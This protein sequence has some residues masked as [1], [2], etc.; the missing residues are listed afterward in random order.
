M[1]ESNRV[2]VSHITDVRHPNDACNHI[3]FQDHPSAI[4]AVNI[5]VYRGAKSWDEVTRLA[6]DRL[7]SIFESLPGFRE[8]PFV[9]SHWTN[10]HFV[11]SGRSAM[12][13]RY[14]KSRA[15]Q[16]SPAGLVHGP[17]LELAR[18]TS[19]IAYATAAL[20]KHEA[21]VETIEWTRTQYD[22]HIFWLQDLVELHQSHIR[23]FHEWT[24]CGFDLDDPGEFVP[25]AM[26]VAANGGLYLR[27]WGA[28]DDPE[29]SIQLYYQPDLVELSTNE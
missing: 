25:F 17:E 26:S 21:L 9:L 4:S 28:F 11:G 13:K 18:S 2:T 16:S 3:W 10:I 6:V 7:F 1:N 22:A 27:R 20:V 23:E 14:W 19:H 5:D 29:L 8:Q 12:Y 15:G 24:Q